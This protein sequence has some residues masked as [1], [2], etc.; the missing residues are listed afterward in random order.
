MR[1]KVA[2]LY[3]NNEKNL[4][5]KNKSPVRLLFLLLRVFVFQLHIYTF[6]IFKLREQKKILIK[7]FQIFF[8]IWLRDVS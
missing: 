6:F 5:F 7:K 1:E 3:N 2:A 4:N 8:Q